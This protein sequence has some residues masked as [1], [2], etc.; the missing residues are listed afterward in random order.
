M[1]TWEN[2]IY[3]I[4]QESWESH[5][6]PGFCSL[7][8]KQ[9]ASMGQCGNTMI[10]NLNYFS[11]KLISW[12]PCSSLICALKLKFMYAFRIQL[13]FWGILSLNERYDLVSGPTLWP[14]EILTVSL[15]VVFPYLAQCRK[16]SRPLTDMWWMRKRKIRSIKHKL[17]SKYTLCHYVYIIRILVVSSCFDFPFCLIL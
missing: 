4:T 14:A 5:E 1:R 7:P 13:R 12:L 2:P 8:K 15:I 16:H 6:D 9:E 3:L 17:L 10:Q 11:S